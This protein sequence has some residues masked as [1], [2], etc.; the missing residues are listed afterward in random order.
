MAACVRRQMFDMST[1]HVHKLSSPLATAT[2]IA[3]VQQPQNCSQNTKAIWKEW[4]G[5]KGRIKVK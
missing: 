4:M 5:E 1:Q 3:L 2:D